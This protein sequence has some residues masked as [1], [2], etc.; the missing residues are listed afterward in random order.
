MRIIRQIDELQKLL[1]KIR[2]EGRTI[3]LVP[4]MGALHEGHLELVNQSI[5]ASDLTVASIFVNEIQFNNPNDFD[6]YPQDLDSDLAKLEDSGCDVVFN[7]S[8]QVMY[9]ENP[10][11]EMRFGHLEE[12]MEGKYR[13]GHFNGVGIVV[14]KLLNIIR[15]D[16]AFFGQKDLQ[17]VAVIK[18]IVKDLSIHVEIVTVP[19]IREEDGLALSSRNRRLS[20]AHRE[21]A[22]VFYEA[23]Q[24]AEEMMKTEKSVAEIRSETE[25]LVENKE[26]IEL[27]YF[28]IVE[29]PEFRICTELEPGFEYGICIAGYAGEVRLI[30]NIL[31]TLH[32]HAD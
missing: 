19:T 31:V 24:L 6:A 2:N 16:F 20:G 11:V 7:P 25:K 32:R 21:N 27:E 15:P 29:L 26:G 8:P 22:V 5:S 13:P 4:T 12:S 3:G 10:I 23:L 28:E 30:D 14:S 18:R 9:P 1:D 17:Q